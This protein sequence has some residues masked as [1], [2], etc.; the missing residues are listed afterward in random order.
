MREIRRALLALIAAAVVPI[1][2]FAHRTDEYLHA[3]FIGIRLDHV[4]LQL[5]LTPGRS[6]S[7]AV[8]AEMDLDHDGRIS[9]AEERAYGTNVLR[10][11]RMTADGRP[12]QLEMASVR[13]PNSADLHEGMG[14]IELKARAATDRFTDG[15][16]VLQ[17]NNFH[18]NHSTVYLAN[19]LQPETREI[20]ILGQSRD[21]SQS[22]LQ[23]RF[24]VKAGVE[25]QAVGA[26][27]G[28][29]ASTSWIGMIIGA[30]AGVGVTIAIWFRCRTPGK[31]GRT[32]IFTD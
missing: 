8:I 12:V 1:T 20:E 7:G 22:K 10:Q 21:V 13:F 17:L 29:P 15:Q 9:E 2:G 25:P 16:H 28:T 30:I 23:I 5:S 3:A 18:T 14:I 31:N 11:I 26:N 32:R 19:A 6:I 24:E 4:E 27:R